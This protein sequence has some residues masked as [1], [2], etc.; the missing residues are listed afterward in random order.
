[1]AK[2]IIITIAGES[3]R[4]RASTQ[5]DVLKALYKKRMNHVFWIFYLTTLLKS[6]RILLLWEDIILLN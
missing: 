1:M 3:K 4:F 6:L 2:A 5:Q